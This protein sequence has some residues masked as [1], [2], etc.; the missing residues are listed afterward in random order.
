MHCDFAQLALVA[1]MTTSVAF[2]T[3][4]LAQTNSDDTGA[5]TGATSAQ[6]DSDD[7][8]ADP[9]D[10]AGEAAPEAGEGD[11]AE[12]DT[13]LSE[14]LDSDDDEKEPRPNAKPESYFVESAL[15]NADVIAEHRAKMEKAEWQQYRADWA[16]FPKARAES[17]LSVVPSNADPDNVRNNFDEIGSFDIGPVFSQSVS[18]LVP[19]YTFDRIS[20]AQDLAELGI[21]SEE[22]KLEGARR[23][24][25]FQ[26]RRA[27]YAIQLSNALGELLA[28]GGELIKEQLEEM[29]DARDFGEADFDIEDFRKL[30]IFNAEV[31]ARRLDNKKLETIARAGIRYF[32]KVD[33]GFTVK[34]LDEDAQPAELS[35]LATYQNAALTT[36]PEA[37]LLEQAV[38]ARRLQKELAKSEFY[39]NI[40]FAG[41]FR[42]VG[43][44]EN[45]AL[46]R[47][48]RQTE[49]GGECVDT[50]DLVAPPYN[51]SLD[52][53]SFGVALGMRWDFDFPQL[54]G[55]FR[56]TVAL[57]NEV[58]AQKQRALGAIELEVEKLWTD[59]SN[60]YE[61][62]SIQERRLEAARRWRDQFG[63][64]MQQGGGDISD[65]VEPLKAYFEARAL[66]LQAR[67][68]YQ[69]SRAEL[70]KAVGVKDLSDVD[71]D[72]K[73]TDK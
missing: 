47:V 35:D 31:D 62:V 58:A 42:Y 10:T 71:G 39:P 44:T 27:F 19:V 23:D 48:C 2:A 7:A 32:A 8:S 45:L 14:A 66:Y 9:Q 17:G 65:A 67:F 68:E 51:N 69:V 29:E 26:V 37:L 15:Q 11:E 53:L 36:R 12:D 56:E 59:A 60:A 33:P 1:L 72:N 52:V 49:P 63:L 16:W 21:D 64:S 54:Y 43:S 22:L 5:E 73:Q 40:F 57:N 38:E 34:R 46:Q 6:D 50:A 28:E 24:V 70:A 13:S 18:I 41:T 55:K 4:A 25:E 20:V 3:P 61:K 30:E